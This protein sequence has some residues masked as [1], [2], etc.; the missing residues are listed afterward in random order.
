MVE[1]GTWTGPDSQAMAVERGI[2]KGPGVT[3]MHASGQV[4]KMCAYK[5]EQLL[6]KGSKLRDLRARLVP[7]PGLGPLAVAVIVDAAARVQSDTS[8]ALAILHGLGWQLSLP[9]GL[10]H[11]G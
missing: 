1:E 10:L 6:I 2:W 4:V 3:F 11:G 7:G 8:L 9:L 5:L